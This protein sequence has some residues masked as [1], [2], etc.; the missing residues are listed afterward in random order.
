MMNLEAVMYL[1]VGR[2]QRKS[3]I[4]V[5]WTFEIWPDERVSFDLSHELAF[6]A[7]SSGPI[8]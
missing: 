5:D 8:R 1:M 4:C 6:H 3:M 2:L 7:E